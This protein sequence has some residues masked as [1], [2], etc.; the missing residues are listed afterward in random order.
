MGIL[1]VNMVQVGREV[2]E[3]EQPEEQQGHHTPQQNRQRHD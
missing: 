1:P 3:Y 2:E